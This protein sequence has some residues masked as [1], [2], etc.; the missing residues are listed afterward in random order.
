VGNAIQTQ[1]CNIQPCANDIQ[2]ES[3]AK[4]L[5]LTIQTKQ[6]SMRP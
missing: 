4:V 2:Q 3:Y 5:P 1:P 6:F